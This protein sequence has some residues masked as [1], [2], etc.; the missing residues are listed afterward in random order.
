MKSNLNNAYWLIVNTL[1]AFIFDHKE[2]YKFLTLG[3]FI[4]NS[5]QQNQ[6]YRRCLY[7][8]F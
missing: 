4:S 5:K 2:M 3:P 7:L 1:I 6:I 8:E